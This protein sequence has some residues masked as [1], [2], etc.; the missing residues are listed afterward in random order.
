MSP[1]LL[2]SFPAWAVPAHGWRTEGKSSGFSRRG[3]ANLLHLGLER[4]RYS[5]CARID[6]TSFQ[7]LRAA[8]K[9]NCGLLFGDGAVKDTLDG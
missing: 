8:G 9:W 5:G 6:G 3:G 4:E 1:C 2:N 7:N